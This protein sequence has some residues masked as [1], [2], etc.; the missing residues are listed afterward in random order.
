MQGGTFCRNAER[1]DCRTTAE[2]STIRQYV[3][4]GELLSLV[5]AQSNVIAVKLDKGEMSHE[6]E[7]LELATDV[8][9]ATTMEQ[10]CAYSS[11]IVGA[12]QGAVA[13]Q[14][15][16]AGARLMRGY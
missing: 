1:A 10:E 3:R 6:Q 4:D 9:N 2:N 7:Q 13:T 16:E 15:I 14:Q 11:G 8:T 5:Q 12:A